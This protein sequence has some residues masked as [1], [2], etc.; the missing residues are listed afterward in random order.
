MK[1]RIDIVV[2]DAELAR[3]DDKQ[4]LIAQTQRF[5][6]TER[7]PVFSHP[8]QWTALA[9]R[10]V[11]AGEYMRSPRD[12]PARADPQPEMARREHFR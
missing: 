6:P 11:T 7:V 3:N 8:N 2:P 9:A 5:E 4:A 12:N 10:G 1:E